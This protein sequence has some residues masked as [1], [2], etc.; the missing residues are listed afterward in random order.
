M[1]AAD[2]NDPKTAAKQRLPPWRS[3]DEGQRAAAGGGSN[4]ACS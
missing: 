1:T 4:L 2:T 3:Q